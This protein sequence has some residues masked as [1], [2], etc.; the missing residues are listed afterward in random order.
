M[1]PLK[2]YPFWILEFALSLLLTTQVSTR[3]VISILCAISFLEFVCLFSLIITFVLN[4]KM[5]VP[6]SKWVD[7][8]ETVSCIILSKLCNYRRDCARQVPLCHWLLDKEGYLVIWI[9][10]R[11]WVDYFHYS[12]SLFVCLNFF[13]HCFELTFVPYFYLCSPPLSF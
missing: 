11:I 10:H 8:F 5:N 3:Y 9:L 1:W 2:F 7:F 12:T 6:T 4:N 13:P